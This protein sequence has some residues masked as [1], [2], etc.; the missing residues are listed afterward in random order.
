MSDALIQI[1]KQYERIPSFECI[2]GC[3]SCCG[4]VPFAEAE[5]AQL[6][7][8][9]PLTTHRCQFASETGCT[10][11]EHRP[12]LC[13]LFG[14]VDTPK[15]LCPYGKRPETLMTERQGA[16]IMRHF[17]KHPLGQDPMADLSWAKEL[18]R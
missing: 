15:L 8:P 16:T 4:P 5:W 9:P 11:Y 13:R 12:L 6:T 17:L 10:I 2:P 18:I 1:K 14:T 7:D 3:V